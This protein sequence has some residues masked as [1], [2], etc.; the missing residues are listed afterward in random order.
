MPKMILVNA[1]QNL[2]NIINLTM[3]ISTTGEDW[4]CWMVGGA[5]GWKTC[6]NAVGGRRL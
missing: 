2:H 1:S 6:S 5:V 3:N 4:S